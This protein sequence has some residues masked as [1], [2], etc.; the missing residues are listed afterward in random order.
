MLGNTIACCTGSRC[1]SLPHLPRP[2]LKS[3]SAAPRV[4]ESLLCVWA[5]ER[6]S[7][8]HRE[9]TS[10]EHLLS[11]CHMPPP[12]SHARRG[13]GGGR[14]KG[15]PLPLWAFFRAPTLCD[16]WILEAQVKTGNSSKIRMLT[17]GKF[18]S[19][20]SKYKSGFESR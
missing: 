2:P 5:G 7:Q 3:S 9:L 4:S 14:R 20:Y 12:S 18:S 1:A 11:P 6:Y 10:R 17:P 16:G 15:A 19:T 13:A 8:D